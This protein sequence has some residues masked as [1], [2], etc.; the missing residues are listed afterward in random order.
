LALDAQ[1]LGLAQPVPVRR[2]SISHR[3]RDQQRAGDQVGATLDIKEVANSSLRT[4]RFH[5]NS[6]ARRKL[7]EVVLSKF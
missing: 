5:R 7:C 4:G 2:C 6:G 3:A 1:I